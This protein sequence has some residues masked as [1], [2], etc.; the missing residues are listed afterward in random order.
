MIRYKD[1][2]PTPFDV[3][4]LCGKSAGISD[5]WLLYGQNRDSDELTAHNFKTALKELGGE[6]E[7]VQVHLF[8]HWA[9]GWLE[10][11]LVRP[12]TEAEKKAREIEERLENYPI[13]DEHGFYQENPDYGE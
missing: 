9:C 11:L 1:Y 2:S 3:K 8:K 10:V 13:L 7:D 4:G 12:D 6:S 5:F